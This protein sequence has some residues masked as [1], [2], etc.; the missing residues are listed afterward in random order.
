MRLKQQQHFRLTLGRGGRITQRRADHSRLALPIE[1][2]ELQPSYIFVDFLRPSECRQGRT[3]AK[4][5]VI[6]AKPEAISKSLETLQ[7]TD[8]TTKYG[9]FDRLRQDT[10]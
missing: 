1:P 5:D 2:L 9:L 4:E 10:R 8:E 7:R 3:C 6:E